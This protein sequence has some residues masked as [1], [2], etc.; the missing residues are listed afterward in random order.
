MG[1]ATKSIVFSGM[2][3]L[4][5]QHTADIGD[6]S[7]FNR[8]NISL[9]ALTLNSRGISGRTGSSMIN[10]HSGSVKLSTICNRGMGNFQ[11]GVYPYLSKN[12]IKYIDI[13]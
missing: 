11:Q 9:L 10:E 1:C 3:S 2:V 4:Y 13:D 5:A 7:S 8:T 6:P 12:Q